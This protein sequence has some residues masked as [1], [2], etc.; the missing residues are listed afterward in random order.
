[1]AKPYNG[2]RSWNAW[3][4]ALWVANDEAP[5][6]LTKECLSRN[7]LDLATSCSC[8]SWPRKIRKAIPEFARAGPSVGVKL[9]DTGGQEGARYRAFMLDCSSF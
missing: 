2:H 4:V 8:S 3:N 6:R 1:M 7:N 5:Y 9:R